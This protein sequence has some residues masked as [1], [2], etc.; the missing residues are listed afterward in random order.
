MRSALE[1]FAS[2][3]PSG[4]RPNSHACNSVIACLRN[5]SINDALRVFEI[6]RKDDMATCHTYSLVL[7]AIACVQGCASAKA[8]RRT[9]PAKKKFDIF[10]YNMMIAVCGKAKVEAEKLWREL[11]ENELNRT[12]ITYSLLVS[13]FVQCGQMELALDACHEMIDKGLEPSEDVMKAIVADCTKE[14]NWPVA[15]KVFEEMLG[16]GMKSNVIAYNEVINCL[17]KAGKVDLAFSIYDDMKSSWLEPDVYTWSAL[18]TAPYRSQRYFDTLQF[19]L[20]HS[21][22]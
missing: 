4:R 18:L 14:R 5:E 11:K 19:F 15:L 20:R 7:K 16:K 12:M 1:L 8:R 6:V 3:D 22:K 21:D 9:L 13:T 17:G 10:V 2:V